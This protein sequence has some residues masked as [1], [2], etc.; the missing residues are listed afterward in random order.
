M[1]C[2]TLVNLLPPRV[3]FGNNPPT[4]PKS[5]AYYL[6]RPNT[7]YYFHSIFNYIIYSGQNRSDITLLSS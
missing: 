6:N 2:G 3:T 5:V 7:E 4:P 1:S